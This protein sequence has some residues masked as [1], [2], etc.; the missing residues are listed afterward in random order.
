MGVARRQRWTPAGI[1]QGE[2]G[3]EAALPRGAGR[4]ERRSGQVEWRGTVGRQSANC[5]LAAPSVWKEI[6][7]VS[8]RRM[9]VMDNARFR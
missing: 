4:R 9:Q 7:D 5:G 3:P 2:R 8:F 6:E 1:R